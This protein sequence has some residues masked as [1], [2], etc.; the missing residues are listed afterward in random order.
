MLCITLN[1]CILVS[2]PAAA[3]SIFER[4]IN[5]AAANNHGAYVRCYAVTA[6]E[7]FFDWA[8]IT[9]CEPCFDF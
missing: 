7:T 1:F 5:I 9:I 8:I 3:T 4:R 2:P 6:Y